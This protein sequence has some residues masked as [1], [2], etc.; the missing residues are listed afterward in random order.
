MNYCDFI[1]AVKGERK[2]YFRYLTFKMLYQI[3][4][5]SHCF[6]T[7]IEMIEIILMER[8]SPF[9]AKLNIQLKQ[10]LCMFKSG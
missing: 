4:Q 9:K 1:K 5:F 2:F 10:S 8:L 3:W 6:H 7:K